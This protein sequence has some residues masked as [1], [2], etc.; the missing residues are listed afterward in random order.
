MREKLVASFA[1][2][3]I[4]PERLILD[5]RF[6][7]HQAHLQAYQQV[8]IAWDRL[9]YPGMATTVDMLWMGVLVLSMRGQRAI[10]H[11][12]ETI[13]HIVGLPKW[14]A[15]DSLRVT[16]QNWLRAE[17]SFLAFH[18]HEIVRDRGHFPKHDRG[19]AV[20]RREREADLESIML[21]GPRNRA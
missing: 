1:R 9:P 15:A 20:T 17:P 16:A 4:S 7:S 12:G 8:D 19:R 13:L 5:G 14:I 18:H 11:Q 10:S 2:F 21:L 3:A 6:A